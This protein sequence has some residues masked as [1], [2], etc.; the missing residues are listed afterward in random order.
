[1]RTPTVEA[2]APPSRRNPASWIARGEQPLEKVC[3]R[4][5]LGAE[6]VLL[7]S[8]TALADEDLPDLTL[9]EKA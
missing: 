5:V 1:L 2:S 3:A 8:R 6:D 4:L 7:I 9:L